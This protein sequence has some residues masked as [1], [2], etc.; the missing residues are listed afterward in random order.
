MQYLMQYLQR[1]PTSLAQSAEGIS[2]HGKEG[3]DG[4]VG[5][6]TEPGRRPAI[7]RRPARS[8]SS[9]RARRAII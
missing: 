6:T 5:D 8:T 3:G 7:T 1:F 4:R 9:S 2:R